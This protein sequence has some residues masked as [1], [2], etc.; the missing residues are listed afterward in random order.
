MGHANAGNNG[1]MRLGN[2]K[3]KSPWKQAP[4]HK[5]I[6]FPGE[7]A[8]IMVSGKPNSLLKFFSDLRVFIFC[9]TTQKTASLA[10]VLPTLPVIPIISGWYFLMILRASKAKKA[11]AKFLSVFI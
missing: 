5:K 6:F 11:C 9:E 10:E 7:S 8:P 2:P 3:Q 1:D 4:S